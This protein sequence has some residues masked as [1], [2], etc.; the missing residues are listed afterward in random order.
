MFSVCSFFLT[1]PKIYGMWIQTSWETNHGIKTIAFTCFWHWCWKNLLFFCF[2]FWGGGG[3]FWAIPYQ[4]IQGMTPLPLK[5][6][7]IFAP[8]VGIIEIW[9]LWKFQLLT[10][11]CSW[12]IAIWKFGQN[13]LSGPK[14][15]ILNLHFL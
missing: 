11:R 15:A 12:D 5:N 6:F 9:K 4:I 2:F 3:G 14:F 10:H 8:F 13:T 1:T 7:F